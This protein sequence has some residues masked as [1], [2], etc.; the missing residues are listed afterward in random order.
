MNASSA[1]SVESVHIPLLV[2]TN[3]SLVILVVTVIFFF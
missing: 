1:G 3:F 2:G